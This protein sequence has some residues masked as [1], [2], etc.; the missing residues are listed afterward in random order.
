M[1]SQAADCTPGVLQLAAVEKA[2]TNRQT[3]LEEVLASHKAVQQGK[4]Q[5][6]SDLLVVEQQLSA[7]RAARDAQL[8]QH[9]SLVG[10]H[11]L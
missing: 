10:V 9:T 7:D 1:L 3:E 5:A 8:Q 11:R 6:K 2:L 4:D